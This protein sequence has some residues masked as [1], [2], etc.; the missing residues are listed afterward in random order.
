[1]KSAKVRTKFLLPAIGAVAAVA[2]V[3]CGGG[4][5]GSSEPPAPVAVS[6]VV[7]DGPLSG[8]KVCYDLNDNGACDATDPTAAATG[9][10]G[11]YSFTVA[12]ADAGKHAVVAEVPATAVDSD[13]G[14]AV[15][16][17]FKLA[18]PATGA[19]VAQ[20]VFVSALTTVVVDMA[21]SSGI[22]STEAAAQVQATLGLPVSPLANFVAPGGN[23]DAALAARAL[24]TLTIDTTLLANAA[25]VPADKTE[26]L[27]KSATGNLGA[28][29]TALAGSTGTT[30]EKVDAAVQA[31]QDE[32]NLTAATVAAV[33]DA[34]GK[35]KDLTSAPGPFVSLR[36]FAYTD[37]NNYSYTLFAGDSSATDSSGAFIAH[38]VRKTQSAG[39]DVPFNRNQDY[40]NG[41]AWVTCNLQWQVV[42]GVKSQT[43]TTPQTSTFCGGSKG[44]ATI[45][46]EDISGRT[47]R[48]VIEQIRAYPLADSP[49]AHTD[50]ITGLPTR[51][52][53]EP[54]LLPAD[55][56]FP[57]GS[58]YN[59][60]S[61][62]AEVGGS[63]RI[64]TTFKSSVRWP[65]GI[66]RQAVTLEQ[67]SGMPGNLIDPAVVPSFGNSVY[68]AD[69]ARPQ[70]ADATLSPFFRFIAGLDVAA[71][72][73]RF[74]KCDS[75]A[76]DGAALNCATV[77]D[78]TLAL[79][80]QGDARLMRVATGY[81]LELESRLKW[82]RFWAERAGTVFRGA[83]DLENVRYDQ[84]LNATAW[85]ALRTALGI[86]AHTEAVA[87]VQFGPVSALRNFTFTDANNYFFRSFDGDSSVRDAQGYYQT[88][89]V[90]ELKSAGV[91]QPFVRNQLY[92]T[93]TEWYDCPS[94]GIRI[95]PVNSVAP[96]DSL[97]CKSYLFE[98][99]TDVTLTLDGRRMSDVV[100]DIRAYGSKDGTFDFRNWGPNPAVHTV[101]ATSTFPVGSTMNYRG[102]ITKNTPIGIATNPATDK[103]RVPP[104]ANTAAPFNTWPFAANLE[105]FIAKYPGDY[106]GAALNGSMAAFVW[107]RFL[108]VAPAGFTTEMQI[109][110][111]FDA[112][113]TKA[114]FY[115]NNI[116]ATTG[117][118]TNYVKLLDTTYTIETV[119][120]KR[121]LRFAAMPAGYEDE[122]KF[123]RMFAEHVDPNG[124]AVWYAFKDSVP[125]LPVWGIRLNGPAFAAL[126][127]ALGL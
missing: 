106:Q 34:L 78:G 16:V 57:A 44:E 75:R 36:R 112:V 27:V 88:N 111:A 74:Y 101:L 8:V 11:K 46:V 3:A 64:E 121:V 122:F 72:K 108:P 47:M 25:G 20:D 31:V 110:V 7:A 89:E 2:L 5:G 116:N 45:A 29:A 94:D 82:Q 60:R 51:W 77:G 87:P 23:A 80:T 68:V 102:L 61:Q 53:P 48:S 84:R 30:A 107:R 14:L 43:A 37:A 126:R 65:D 115:E 19:V 50:P 55:A 59:S 32:L 4:G 114:R 42:T 10:D 93:G 9:A 12:A 38:E 22:T 6:G 41:S 123:Q 15:G 97:F 125:A 109:R 26:A 79:S 96:F 69:L 98:R 117:G 103:L 18:A 17:A 92:R 52:G 40:W 118:T 33:A 99:G 70:P 24:T 63:D 124:L 67:Y 104:A 21:K 86:P 76:S 56:T 28:L 49:G 113:G 95:N 83:R 73:F 1:M 120:G 71:L 90:R 58:S 100:N 127:A 105:D 35:P 119:G 91:V 81:P 39:V 85:N 13:T 66:Y 54:A 62:R